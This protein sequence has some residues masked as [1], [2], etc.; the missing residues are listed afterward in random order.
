M[1]GLLAKFA[2]MDLVPKELQ[3]GPLPK[4]P[5]RGGTLGT[6]MAIKVNHFKALINSDVQIFHYDVII[7]PEVQSRGVN[8][9]VINS[10]VRQYRQ[11]QGNGPSLGGRLPAY[12]GRKNMYTAGPIPG[13]EGSG[14]IF[15][16]ITPADENPG[17]P[18]GRR[19]RS[20]KVTLK[21][22]AKL[23]MYP[24][25][26][27]LAGRFAEQPQDL[28]N[29]VDIILRESPTQKFIPSGRSFYS[30]LFGPPFNLTGGVEAVK[31]FFQT[32]R[33]AQTGLNQPQNYKEVHGLTLNLDMSATAFVKQAFVPDF[34]ADF[35][36]KRPGQPFT[37]TDSE[38]VKVQKVLR[39]LRVETRHQKRRYRVQR[40][41][42]RPLKDLK[43]PMEDENTG[44]SKTISLVDYF[45]TRYGVQLR[46]LNLPCLECEPKKSWI[47]LELCDI[48]A[49][50]KYVRK[51]TG[52]QTSNMLTAAKQYPEQREQMIAERVRANNYSGDPYALEFGIRVNPEMMTVNARVLDPPKLLYGNRKETIP[53]GGAWNMRG[54]KVVDGAKVDRWTCINFASGGGRDCVPNELANNFC[55]ALADMC[56]TT[57]LLMNRQMALPLVSAGPY[58][59]E[60]E[61]VLRHVFEQ[62][63][64]LPS[65]PNKAPLDLILCILPTQNTIYGDIKRYSELTLGQV[66]QCC[67]AKNIG[68]MQPQYLANVALNINPKVGGRNNFLS[69]SVARTIPIVNKEHTILFGADVT[70]PS[71][72]EDAMP[73]IAAVVATMD[74]PQMCTY[75]GL[76]RSQ[77]TRVEM[78]MDLGRDQK[79]GGGPQQPGMVTELLQTYHRRNNVLPA[80][81][82]FYRDGVSEGQFD[83]VRDLEVFAIRKACMAINPGYN[84]K[85]T[86]IVVQKRH[87]TRMFP[88]NRNNADQSGNVLPGT[89]VDTDICH[90]M[91]YD[92][93]LCSHAGIQ[94]VSRPAKYVVLWDENGFGSNDLQNFTNSLCYTYAGCTRSV[95]V[96]PP[97]Y[98]AHKLAFRARFYLNP[99]ASDSGSQ[100]GP[101]KSVAGLGSS[102]T[103][104]SSSSRS[105]RDASEARVQSLP[106]LREFVKSVMFYT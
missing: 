20:F 46:M 4:C 29:A 56:V 101:P 88:T 11:P 87:H 37:I 78:I 3:L 61:D 1:K 42:D 86:F 30:P 24:L 95:S 28:L 44:E 80:R 71:P 70:H 93:F 85:M 64:K 49:K 34:I 99:D 102:A 98:Y 55:K 67:L 32:M 38:R 79:A 35:L 21:L 45:R 14:L 90:P 19:Q 27:F 76:I 53:R 75:L 104:G 82:I 25:Q 103:G 12:D 43:F 26:E 22:A 36:G 63:K 6:K 5:D 81:L 2:S 92:F 77:T 57:G 13:A 60:V 23:S 15:E 89:V 68:R 100:R 59:P 39:G 69:A 33:P 40:L 83:Q 97:A 74:W 72:G 105:S 17:Q 16:D 9:A 48:A 66:T 94:G 54:T 62:G 96:A 47:P 106:E 91:Q 73:S 41:T 10:L 84:P 52:Q 58:M 65:R 8:R 50:Q 18:S 31:G 7:S 51:L